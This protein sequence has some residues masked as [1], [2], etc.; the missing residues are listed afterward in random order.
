MVLTLEQIGRFA[1]YSNMLA[2]KNENFSRNSV[3]VTGKEKQA[4]ETNQ[5]SCDS[6][7]LGGLQL[8]ARSTLDAFL[9][10]ISRTRR[11]VGIETGSQDD[12]IRSHK[13]ASLIESAACMKDT[14]A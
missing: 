6:L 14:L 4:R 13:S 8:L 5:K 9:E 3:L 12:L 10:M 1:T 7:P 2:G 11:P